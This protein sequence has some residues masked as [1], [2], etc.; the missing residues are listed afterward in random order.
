MSSTESVIPN[1]NE[2]DTMLDIDQENVEPLKKRG[3]GILYQ[4]VAIIKLTEFIQ[5]KDATMNNQGF[6]NKFSHDTNL[7]KY[8]YKRKRIDTLFATVV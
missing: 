7:W 1:F 3:K 8:Q 6:I 5:Q 4:E 2:E